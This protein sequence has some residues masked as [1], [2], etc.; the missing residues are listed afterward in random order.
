MIENKYII[1]KGLFTIVFYFVLLFGNQGFSQCIDFHVSGIPNDTSCF[2]AGDD[3]NVN[4]STSVIFSIS[5]MTGA[6]I[7]NSFPLG[8]TT[9]VNWISSPSGTYIVQALEPTGNWQSPYLSLCQDTITISPGTL[10][11]PDTILTYCQWNTVNLVDILSSS[12]INAIT[13]EYVFS[14][15]NTIING[16]N[17][18]INTIY[19]LIDVEVTDVSGCITTSQITMIGI[20]NN[21]GSQEFTISDTVI[22]YCQPTLDTFSINNPDTVN[23]TYLW[24]VNGIPNNSTSFSQTINPLNQNPGYFPVSLIITQPTAN[25]CSVTYNDTI[26]SLGLSLGKGLEGQE[27]PLCEG[28]SALFWPTNGISPITEMGPLDTL[29]WS[30]R[31]SNTVLLDT[32]WVYSDLPQLNQIYQPILNPN[33]ISA[34]EFIFP[35]NS[36]NCFNPN[37]S[38]PLFE[39]YEISVDI[40]RYCISTPAPAFLSETVSSPTDADFNSPGDLC[41]NEAGLFQNS[42]TAGC[43]NITFNDLLDT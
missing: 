28:A 19:S 23:F 36:C 5:D 6:P 39:Q 2:I 38:P 3:I 24:D 1:K 27:T 8:L 41:V 4:C 14:I 16:N 42:S 33:G 7:W 15:G 10:D 9:S 35:T 18:E 13:P 31:C 29:A 37:T 40:K 32:F 25:G 21:I 30:I 26:V 17:F 34:F 20:P 12:L 43:D 22:Q 11:L